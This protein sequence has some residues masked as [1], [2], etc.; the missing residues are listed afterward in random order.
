[1]VKHSRIDVSDLWLQMGKVPFMWSKLHGLEIDEPWRSV[2]HEDIES[3][4]R[5]MDEPFAVCHLRQPS[6]PINQCLPQ[7]SAVN[8]HKVGRKIWMLQRTHGSHH[9][10]P[11]GGKGTSIPHRS[12]RGVQVEESLSD[13]PCAWFEGIILGLVRP[14]CDGSRVDVD[15]LLNTQVDGGHH[16]GGSLNEFSD[17]CKFSSC[18]VVLLGDLGD[19]R[20]R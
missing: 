2:N 8:V 16:R 14:E 19:N 7:Q 9:G 4:R 10:F 11:T 3:V 15:G 5:T 12:E 6:N 1:M 20:A 18:G 17:N 13:L